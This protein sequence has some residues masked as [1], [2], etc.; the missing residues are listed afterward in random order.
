MKKEMFDEIY[1]EQDGKTPCRIKLT[2]YLLTDSVSEEYCD[3][4]VYGVEIDKAEEDRCGRKNR[5]KKIIGDL[6]FK[7]NEALEFLR[8]ICDNKVMPMG[9]KYVVNDYIGE[10]IQLSDREKSIEGA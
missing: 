7:K 3:L 4:K 8:K 2:Y 1:L 5:E 6:F 10:R 9:L